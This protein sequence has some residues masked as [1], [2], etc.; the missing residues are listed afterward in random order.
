MVCDQALAITHKAGAEDNGF[1]NAR[2]I[3]LDRVNY[4]KAYAHLEEG[5][6]TSERREN[7]IAYMIPKVMSVAP[8][9]TEYPMMSVFT[10]YPGY[11]F[12]SMTPYEQLKWALTAP[13]TSEER[14]PSPLNPADYIGPTDSVLSFTAT[15]LA[16]AE[17]EFLELS[18]E[19]RFGD[20]LPLVIPTADLVDK[21]LAGTTR[22]PSEILGKVKMRGGLITV[23]K[24][25]I[26]AVMAGAKPEYFPVILAAMEAIATGWENDKMFYH[27]MTTGGPMSTIVLLVN[28]PLAK[29]LGITGD[30]GYLGAGNQ[31]NNTIGRAVKLCWHNIALNDAPFIDQANLAGRLN[32]HTLVVLGEQENLLPSG[33]DP[34]H[35]MMGF[36]ANQSTVTVLGHTQTS[37]F[38]GGEPFAWNTTTVLR[39]YRNMINSVNL[40][41]IPPSMALTMAEVEGFETK[42]DVRRWLATHDAAGNETDYNHQVYMRTYPIIAGGDPNRLAYFGAGALYSTLVH[43][44]QLITGATL[45]DYG[46]DATAPSTP[47]NFKVAHSE[48]GTSVEL[49]WNP[50]INDGG[51]PITGYQVYHLDGG[52]AQNY[53]WINVPDGADARSYTFDGLTLDAE[54]CFRVRAVNGVINSIDLIGTG[55]GTTLSTRASGKGAWASSGSRIAVPDWVVSAE[56]SASVERLSGNNNSLTVTVEETYDSGRTVSYT[57]TFTIENNSEGT[58]I[59]GPYKVYVDT[60]G[61]DQIRECY[62]IWDAAVDKSELA[63]LIAIA[64]EKV[65]TDYVA[66]TWADFASAL[67]DAQQVYADEEATQ[68]QVDAAAAALRAAMDALVFQFCVTFVADNDTEDVIV[69]VPDGGKVERPIDPEKPGF[70]FVDWFIGDNEFEFDFDTPITG[71][72]TLTARWEDESLPSI[73]FKI[74]SSS[75]TSL[76]RNSKTTFSIIIL[77]GTLDEGVIWSVSDT[78][79]ATVDAYGVVTTSNKAGLITLT[80][81]DPISGKIHMISLRIS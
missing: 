29:E 2:R 35:V 63:A 15:S 31:P 32:D 48:D 56:P 36:E 78:S 54:Y 47:Q 28:G 43:Q 81:K 23:E 12:N 33:W 39:N 71:C 10:P 60:K 76:K 40:M 4:S 52:N 62:I 19:L 53:T 80:A 42:D 14:N 21:M 66:R 50:P 58:Y 13:L 34:Y 46:R 65:E 20:G 7:A 67:A 30:K 64:L 59:V 70:R 41:A 73:S 18:L 11:D 22:D 68:E 24:V 3:V 72:L 79:Y 26:N 44:T 57:G 51:S 1:S 69:Y 27:S 75:M 37:R 49:S 9:C 61:N 74:N 25:A 77:N 55:N 38:A 8:T 16:K 17:Q 5:D 6:T 45:T